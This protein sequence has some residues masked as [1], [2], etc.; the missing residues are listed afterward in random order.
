MCSHIYA[1]FLPNFSLGVLN[2]H[3]PVCGFVL[4]TR[5][6]ESPTL[7]DLLRLNCGLHVGL[8][9]LTAIYFR[10]ARDKL[11]L[12]LNA[13]STFFFK[14]CTIFFSNYLAFT[15]VPDAL[16]WQNLFGPPKNLNKIC[17][18]QIFSF[19]IV[20]ALKNFFFR[21]C[22][23]NCKICKFIL[24]Q[25]NYSFCTS[26]SQLGCASLTIC[27]YKTWARSSTFSQKH[28]FEESLALSNV[29]FVFSSSEETRKV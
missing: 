2:P 3:V 11:F 1:P 23:A 4:Y 6:L 7:K 25:I 22:R 29:N 8:D 18:C 28:F 10:K 9:I 26:D 21:S 24:K 5:R 16:V 13:F 27:S 14:Q 15:K 19:V 12:N 17:L 20:G